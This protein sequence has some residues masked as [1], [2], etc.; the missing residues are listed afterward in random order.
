M[1]TGKKIGIIVLS[2]V[3]VVLLLVAGY[4]I[5]Q[6]IQIANAPDP[7]AFSQKYSEEIFEAVKTG[8][9][10]EVLVEKDVSDLGAMQIEKMPETEDGK[11]LYDYCLSGIEYRLEGETVRD[12]A[13]AQQKISLSFPT[14]DGISEGMNSEINAGLA[15]VVA[16]AARAQDVYTEDNNFKPEIVE[17]LYSELLN[18]RL[19]TE[20]KQEKSTEFTML[21]KYSKDEWKIVNKDEVRAGFLSWAD[22]V[23]FDAEAEKI[24]A[25]AT[26]ELTYIPVALKIDEKALRGPLPDQNKFMVTTDPA[27][28]VAVLETEEAKNLIGDKKL[29]WSPDVESIPGR[30]MYCYLDETILVICWQQVEAKAVGTYSEVIVADGSQLRRRIAGDAYEDFNHTTTTEFAKDSNAVL[31]MG[32]DFYH[33][34]RNCGIIVYNR[35]V[36]RFDPSTCDTCYITADGDMLFSYRNQF[37]TLE[38]AQAFVDENDILF[39]LAFGPVL[40]DDYKDVTPDNYPWGEI[41]DHYARSGLGMFEDHHYLGL[42][43]NCQ[44]PDYYYLVT[45]RDLADAMVRAGCRKAYTLDGGQTATTVFNQTLINPVQF[46]WEKPISDVIYFATAVPNE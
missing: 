33:H 20:E 32:G 35:E 21:L 23:D 28:I 14:L 30:E 6:R 17:N 15:E 44:K 4:F 9:Q 38:E 13:N 39:S 42:N 25:E 40:I 19:N 22:G 18:S 26:S 5:M 16:G 45:L 1:S 7:A 12:G 10:P 31:T 37:S 8:E 43:I 46:G 2:A 29:L 34:A 24:K 11:L 36:K 3:L 27:E 41:N